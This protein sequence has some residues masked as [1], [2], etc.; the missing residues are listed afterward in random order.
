MTLYLIDVSSHQQSIPIEAL[1]GQGFS[2]VIIKATQG[3]GYTNPCFADHLRR[4][5]AT[6]RLLVA[7]YHFLA[8]GN[9]AGQ[10]AHAAAVVPADVPIWWDQ[11]AGS[12]L[13]D[14][15]AASAEA[16]RR[17]LR[18]AGNYGSRPP[19]GWGWWR[20][21]YLTD[22]T[23]YA[24]ST[25]AQLGGDTSAAWGPG[26]DLWQYCQ[27]GRVS[28]YSGDVDFS[29]YR[30]TLDQLA[31]SGWFWVPDAL[32]PHPTP[33]PV[34][35]PAIPKGRTDMYVSAS[36]GSTAKAAN[37]KDPLVPWGTVFHC[38]VDPA[39][40]GIRLHLPVE[41]KALVQAADAAGMVVEA[42]ADAILAAYPVDVTP[43]AH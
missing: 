14:S 39:R 35:A 20:A 17:G 37:G 10:A 38:T 2:A 13:S 29:A 16:S 30:G 31:A 21:A 8:P 1:P 32:K 6:G 41:A 18:T 22:P 40:G 12:S 15:L 23:G 5:K 11:E 24:A 34:Q 43:P 4:A 9:G 42:P 3:T 19:K 36:T 28:G 33:K 25:Y 27:H 7:A 26:Q